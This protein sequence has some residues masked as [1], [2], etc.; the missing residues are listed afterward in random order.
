VV[1]ILMQ[2]PIVHADVRLLL[3]VPVVGAGY[4]GAALIVLVLSLAR[5][6]V[7]GPNALVRQRARILCAAFVLG[8]VPPIL[9]TVAEAL[10]QVSVPYLNAMWKLPLLFPIVMA[11]AMVR[12]DLFDVRAALRAGAV[13]SGATGLVV[14]AYAGRHRVDGHPS[15]RT[16]RRRSRRSSRRR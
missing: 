14:L 11:Y 1:A 10:F 3:A 8:Y 2:L 13:Y 7:V 4:W 12:Y 15:S 9:G 16:G 5:A 6:S